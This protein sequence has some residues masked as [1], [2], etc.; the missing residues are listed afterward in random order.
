MEPRKSTDG[1]L[2]LER[3]ATQMET[4]LKSI[5]D[6]EIRMRKLEESVYEGRGFAKASSW[7]ITIGIVGIG[8][9]L[10]NALVSYFIR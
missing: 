2:K 10:A 1:E 4:A 7:W 9:I 6:H 8:G 3:Q 5:Q